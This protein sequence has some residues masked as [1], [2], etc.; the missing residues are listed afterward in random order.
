LAITNLFFF[1]AWWSGIFVG[2]SQTP[3]IGTVLPAVLT[4][5]TGLLAYLFSKE[6][7]VD[8]RPVIPNCI[9]ALL[10]TV[11]FGA[12]MGSQIRLDY[13]ETEKGYERWL[14]HYEKIGLP[15]AKEGYLKILNG[16][17]L[18]PQDFDPLLRLKNEANR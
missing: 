3:V 15:V 16:E 17:K 6:N 10:L 11:L 14:L 1:T 13:E 2:A 5:I 8:W 18:S 12:F 9:V 4:F 7:L